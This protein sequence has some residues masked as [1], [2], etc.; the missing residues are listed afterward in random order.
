MCNGELKSVRGTVH[1]KK[2]KVNGDDR[3]WLACLYSC[4]YARRPMTVGQALNLF[5]MRNAG[6]TPAPGTK[7][8]FPEHHPDWFLHVGDAFPWLKKRRKVA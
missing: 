5:K 3:A 2:R 1:K 8:M 4:A 6:R 7:F